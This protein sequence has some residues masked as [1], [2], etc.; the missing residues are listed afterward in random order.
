MGELDSPGWR[1]VRFAFHLGVDPWQTCWWA[2]GSVWVG[3][4]KFFYLCVCLFYFNIFYIFIS[5]YIFNYIYI[6]IYMYTCVCVCVLVAQSCSVLCD[7][8]D[9]S[10]PGS[11]VHGMLQARILKWI[12]ILFSK[13]SSQPRDQTQVCIAG[14]FF[15]V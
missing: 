3:L 14:R 7:P 15:T 8:I 1:G 12:A 10:P 9:C 5:T 13:G 4:L 11:S 2:R 6:Y